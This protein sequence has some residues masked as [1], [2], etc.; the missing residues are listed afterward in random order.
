M[1]RNYI[2]QKE[3]ELLAL[4]EAGN[5]RKR[6]E[7]SFHLPYNPGERGYY[8]Y[9]R[10]IPKEPILVQLSEDAK[11]ALKDK[12]WAKEN[13]F[14]EDA[15]EKWGISDIEDKRLLVEALLS[16]GGEEAEL[17]EEDRSLEDMVYYGTYF[18]GR[19]KVAVPWEKN[20]RLACLEAYY[21]NKPEYTGITSTFKVV[22]GYGL[23]EDGIWRRHTWISENYQQRRYTK[24]GSYEKLDDRFAR[25]RVLERSNLKFLAYYGTYQTPE[26]CD[27][28]IA[29]WQAAHPAEAEARDA[30]CEGYLGKQEKKKERKALRE[31]KERLKDPARYKEE[32]QKRKVKKLDFALAAQIKQE[33][34]KENRPVYLPE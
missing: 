30:V 14:A 23:C 21:H 5:N 8:K 7:K 15:V 22:E 28:R 10:R 1:P 17:L 25:E 11:A 34:K 33:I 24:Y 4:K 2:P 27:E 16:I 18:K 29:E 9:L 20:T 26:E 3:R 32:A 6:K 13:L 31:Y 19:S 12:W